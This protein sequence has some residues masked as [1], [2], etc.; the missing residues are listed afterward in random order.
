MKSGHFFQR[1]FHLQTTGRPTEDKIMMGHK[2]GN[3]RHVR[4][5]SS[6]DH[7][8]CHYKYC[9]STNYYWLVA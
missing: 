1:K 9:Y 8:N 5:P 6:G 7:F 2:M 4:A 3:L